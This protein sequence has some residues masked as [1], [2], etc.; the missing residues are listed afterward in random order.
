MMTLVICN[1]RLILMQKQYQPQI[2]V[3][4][5]QLRTFVESRFTEFQQVWIKVVSQR[6]QEVQTT[7][8]TLMADLNKLSQNQKTILSRKM[9]LERLMNP[10]V[11][12]KHM[13]DLILSNPFQAHEN[14]EEKLRQDPNE[15]IC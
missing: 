13:I 14:K 7:L 1:S 5:Q 4:M 6:V 11:T 8:Q 12:Q 2:T 15:T 10:L 3:A 9:E